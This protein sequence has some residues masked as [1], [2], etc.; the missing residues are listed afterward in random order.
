MIY[1]KIYVG[2]GPI[3][4]L[5][6][7]NNFL[8]NEKILIIDKSQNLGGAWKPINLFGDNKVENAVHYLLPNEKGY[9]FLE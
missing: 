1:D 2:S 7:I 9:S 3:L 4:M 6:A 5:D 8:K